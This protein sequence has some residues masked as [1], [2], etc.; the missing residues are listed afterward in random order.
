MEPIQEKKNPFYRL[1]CRG[2]QTGMRAA[3][4]LLPFRTPRLMQGA[5][6][7]RRLPGAIRKMGIS[8]VLVITDPGISRQDFLRELL[9]NLERNEV[10]WSLYDKTVVN[11]TIDNIEQA[12]D[13]YRRSKCQAILAVGG[14]SPIDCAKAAAARIAKPG[15]PVSRMKGVL[16][17]HKKLPVLIAVPTTSG[18]GSEV[19]IAAVVTDAVSKEKYAITDTSLT[20]RYAVLD[21]VLTKDLPKFMTATTGM[22]ALTHAVEAYIGR[23]NTGKTK[24]YAWRAVRI[25]FRDLE[26]VYENG[27]NLL[28]RENMQKAAYFAGAA[29]TR[30]YVGYVHAL[31]HA[32]GGM[33]GT[34][35]GLANAVILPYVLEYYGEAV[36]QPLSELADVAG[37]G[38]AEMTE[39]ERADLFIAAIRRM[40]YNMGIPEHLSDI[41]E[42]DIGLLSL[43]AAREANPLYPVPKILSRKDLAFLYSQIKGEQI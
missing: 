41:R 17:V 26:R 1:G 12:A 15:Q 32:L 7:I 4:Y 43:R 40:N 19:T 30:A 13:L 11:P 31:A 25:I 3:A 35:H 33:Y 27:Q 2:F 18:T 29:F 21:P 8:R 23:S 20:P 42:A 16:K 34:P 38:M 10:A 22:D 28:L 14:G 5:G 24:K 36:Y 6:S 39:A 9:S 37:I